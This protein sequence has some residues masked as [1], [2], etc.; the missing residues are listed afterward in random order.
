MVTQ[1]ITLRKGDRTRTLADTKAGRRLQREKYEPDGWEP[2][3]V[4]SEYDQEREE[5]DLKKFARDEAKRLQAEADAALKAD[6]A[7]GD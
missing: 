3:E 6:K 4:A 7:K 1:F 2:V 5:K